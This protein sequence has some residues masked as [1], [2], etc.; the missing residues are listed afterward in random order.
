MTTCHTIKRYIITKVEKKSKN[1]LLNSLNFE[2]IMMG[3]FYINSLNHTE[4]C[5]FKP[6]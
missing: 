1:Q 6:H 4:F 2:V 5:Q 3:I